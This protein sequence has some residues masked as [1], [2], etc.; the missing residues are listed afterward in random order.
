METNKLYQC[1]VCE[2]QHDETVDGP[3]E[4]LPK[5]WNCPECGCAKE[6]YFEVK[7]D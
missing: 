5:Y 4:L 1:S 2:H 7:F 6:E 3:W